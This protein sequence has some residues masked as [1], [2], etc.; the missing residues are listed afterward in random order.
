MRRRRE[1]PNSSL[2]IELFM[3]RL[4]L[5]L[6]TR[7]LLTH[8]RASRP[9]FFTK[10]LRLRLPQGLHYSSTTFCCLTRPDFRA[11]D[12]LRSL[13]LALQFFPVA[14]FA[15][16][17]G[18]FWSRSPKA[19]QPQPQQRSFETLGN[20]HF[21]DSWGP[22]SVSLFYLSD[23]SACCFAAARGRGRRCRLPERW[24]PDTISTAQRQTFPPFCWRAT[25]RA[26]QVM[27]TRTSPAH[28]STHSL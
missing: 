28:R 14:T 8:E 9:S 1:L 5:Y 23:Y 6:I 27:S 10:G 21:G 4:A 2:P 25:L 13:R 20:F 11:R 16:P 15:S 12:A 7:T 24:Y 17:D 3:R 26:S 19:T 22:D 18:T